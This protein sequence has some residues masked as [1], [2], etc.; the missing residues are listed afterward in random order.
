VGFEVQTKEKRSVKA[1]TVEAYGQAYQR[2]FDRTIRLLLSRGARIDC[3]REAAQAA[4]AKGW[5]RIGQLRNESVVTSWVNT[6]ALNCYRGVMRSE[7]LQL[8]LTDL[9]TSAGVNVAF[10][11]LHRFLARCRPSDRQLFDDYLQGYPMQ[12]IAGRHGIS[13]TAARIRLLRARRVLQSR[14]KERE[15]VV[16]VNR[17]SVV[18]EGQIAA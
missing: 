18:A 4:W 9:E 5:E 10:I 6:I 7:G 1:M 11:D 13:H 15:S 12:E 17:S 8:P 2:G 14:I 3:A 16:R